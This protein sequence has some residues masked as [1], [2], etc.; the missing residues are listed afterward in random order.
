MTQG[1]EPSSA[2]RA[3]VILAGGASR[4]FGGTD[5][6]LARLDGRPLLSHVAE[7]LS[8]DGTWLAINTRPNDA[9][10][11]FG[12]PL[13]PDRVEGGLGPLAGVLTAMRWAGEQG[14]DAVFT[15]PA[16]TPFL[17]DS[18]LDEL[19]V[20]EAAIVMARSGGQVHHICG[21]WQ[22]ALADDLERTLLAGDVRAVWAYAERH[23]RALVDFEAR[24]GIDP[25]FN[26]NTPADLEKAEGLLAG[27]A[28]R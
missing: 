5:K 18:L 12:L 24:G 26:I 17:P 7:R 3:V 1:T 10:S 20:P 23:T 11:T 14:L 8:G 19:S 25:F 28:G 2:G 13:L 16:D 22:T 9:Y 15:A 4:R 27:E 6:A 21:R